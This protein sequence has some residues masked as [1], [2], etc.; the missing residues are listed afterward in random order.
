MAVIL[1]ERKWQAISHWPSLAQTKNV[2]QTS[3][4]LTTV[5]HYIMY[6]I[7]SARPLSS[8]AYTQIHITRADCM[9]QLNVY[10]RLALAA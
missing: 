8:P 6:W 7:Y 3:V 5:Q 1:H 4:N 9:K 10:D 2:L